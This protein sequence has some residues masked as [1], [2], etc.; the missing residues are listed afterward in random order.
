MG[1][2]QKRGVLRKM[3]T[4]KRQDV[5]DKKKIEERMTKCRAGLGMSG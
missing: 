3:E 1:K 2:A 5:E 4:R